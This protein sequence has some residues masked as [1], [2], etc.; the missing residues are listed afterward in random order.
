MNFDYLNIVVLGDFG[1]TDLAS[2]FKDYVVKSS[3]KKHKRNP[4]NLGLILGDNVYPRG[5]QK[6]SHEMLRRIFTKCFPAKTFQ[7]RF[8]AILGNHDYEGIPERQIRYHF[9]VDER[10]YMPY[11]YYIYGMIND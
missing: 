6:E 7:F 1:K 3:K 2:E 4:F 11:R 9:E 5:V 10:F 8:L